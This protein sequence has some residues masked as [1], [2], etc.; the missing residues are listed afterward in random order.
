LVDCI[1]I[2][3]VQGKPF[4]VTELVEQVSEHLPANSTGKKAG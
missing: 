3:K 4:S 1:G 2:N